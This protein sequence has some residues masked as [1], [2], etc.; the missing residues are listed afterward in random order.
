MLLLHN[1]YI[2]LEMK[3]FGALPS[4]GL[5][6]I[7]S[8]NLLNISL[9]FFTFLI[10]LGEA[11]IG[12]IGRYPR[13]TNLMWNLSMKLHMKTIVGIFLGKQS[14]RLKTPEKL[15]FFFLGLHLMINFSLWIIFE[16]ERSSF[17]Y[18]CCKYKGKGRLVTTFYYI[19]LLQRTFGLGFLLIWFLLGHP[20]ICER[21]YSLL[22]KWI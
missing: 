18:W 16:R 13:T 1:I 12:S 21:S 19:M 20:L 11:W 5:L 17:F 7:G 22:E 4:P 9:E 3:F 6:M 15:P 2:D 8:L 10:F 14:R